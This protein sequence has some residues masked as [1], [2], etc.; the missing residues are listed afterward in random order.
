MKKQKIKAIGKTDNKGAF[1]KLFRYLKPHAVS[2]GI[3]IFFSLVS[4]ALMIFAALVLKELTNTISTAAV[5]AMSG[6]SAMSEVLD[7]KKVIV[8]CA[9]LCAAYG[10]SVVL[11]FLQ[12]FILA[13]INQSVSKKLREDITAKIN[14]LPLSYFD[15]HQYGDTLSVIT[16]DVETL[17]QALET[18]VSSLVSSVFQILGVLIAMFV[19]SWQMALTELATLPISMAFLFI[20]V[21]ISQNFYVNQQK[22]LGTVNG[23]VEEA[24]SGQQ[25]IKAFNAE[26]TIGTKFHTNNKKLQQVTYKASIINGFMFPL[27]QFMSK[28]GYIAVCIVGGVLAANGSAQV[29]DLAAFIVFIN[30]FQSPI[31]SLGQITGTLQGGSAA[32]GRI[33]Q[34]LESTE[35]SDETEKTTCLSP[36]NVKGDVVFQN[37]KFGYSPEKTIINDFNLDVKAG[38]KVA[39]VGPTGAGKTTLVNLLMRFYEIDSGKILIDGKPISDLT[40][41]NVRQLFSMVLQDTWLFEGTIK[42]NILYT[43]QNVSDNQLEKVIQDA[44]LSHY[45]NSLPERYNHILDDETNLS[46]GQKQLLTIARAM[47]EDS[48]ILILDEA[49]S[50][51]DTRTE[52]LIQNAMDSLSKGKTSFVIA[53]RLST[54]KNADVILVLKDGD[55]IEQGNHD[56]LLKAN[57]FYKELYE[58]QFSAN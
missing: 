21:K 37:V 19:T 35:E 44:N 56:E 5:V 30:L 57:G 10:L 17:S 15:T 26:K 16:N 31:N 33:F 8:Y 41:Q 40:R 24:F 49:T 42:E 53:H 50:N 52:I 14:R 51:V 3:V 28:I 18:T 58:T 12:S 36:E 46:G 43:A 45:V 22:Y 9:V 13:K 29:G 47:L 39:I 38:Q 54:I 6:A 55:I 4:V 27:M 25:I 2:S 23:A 32:A 1:I 20:F 11:S 48:P 34:L 7:F